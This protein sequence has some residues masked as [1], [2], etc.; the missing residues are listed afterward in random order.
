MTPQQSST[1]ANVGRSG[2]QGLL[3]NLKKMDLR[4]MLT[5]SRTFSRMQEGVN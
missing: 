3:D 4:G 5:A 2:R 1:D